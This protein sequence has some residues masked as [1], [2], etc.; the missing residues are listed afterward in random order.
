[1]KDRM[2]AG[3][4]GGLG[5]FI[6]IIVTLVSLRI[7]DYVPIS[8]LNPTNMCDNLGVDKMNLIRELSQKGLLLTP[9]EYT[10]HILGYYNSIITL[11][12]ASFVVFSFIGYFSIKSR[13]KEQIQE[14]LNDMLRD[15]KTFQNTI[16]SNI[17]GRIEDDFVQK[18]EYE[19]L[20]EKVRI[21]EEFKSE[22]ENK[23][24]NGDSMTTTTTT[25]IS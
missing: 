3:F 9:E 4:S 15:S 6:L 13:I 24:Q 22:Y 23:L 17:N 10:N 18:I 5:T 20:L 1:M 21:L 19:A 25:I 12:I 2:I 11:L 8:I 16:L 7:Y 14:T